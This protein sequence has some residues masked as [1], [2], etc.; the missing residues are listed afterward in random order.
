M[1]A[2]EM[3]RDSSDRGHHVS[4]RYRLGSVLYRRS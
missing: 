3:G 2:L 4:R 1:L